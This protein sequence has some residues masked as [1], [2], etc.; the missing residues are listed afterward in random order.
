M[1]NFRSYHYHRVKCDVPESSP[2]PMDRVEQTVD[3]A[4]MARRGR[5]QRGTR[6]GRRRSSGTPPQITLIAASIISIVWEIMWRGTRSS[7]RSDD[8]HAGIGAFMKADREVELLGH[9]PEGLVSG[10]V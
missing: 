1:T 2:D 7:K 5:H 10:V 6:I 3:P 4:Q 8:G 9:R